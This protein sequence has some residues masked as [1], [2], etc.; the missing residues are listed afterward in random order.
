M[1]LAYEAVRSDRTAAESAAAQVETATQD[2]SKGTADRAALYDAQCARN[3]A[4]AALYQA[5]GT[6]AHYANSLNTCLLY[7]SQLEEPTMNNAFSFPFER[8]RYFYGKLL[9]VRDFEVEQ[10]YHLSL[11]H[12]WER[13][14]T[15]LSRPPTAPSSSFMTSPRSRR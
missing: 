1:S 9:T 7:T 4:T 11:I 13:S 15:S 12:I 6:F 2:Y 14:T 5:M 10:R 8:N 3:E